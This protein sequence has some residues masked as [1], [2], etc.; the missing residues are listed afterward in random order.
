MSLLVFARRFGFQS[1]RA[2]PCG[3][4]SFVAFERWADNGA[5]ALLEL[6][7]M[8]NA[9]GSDS[10]KTARRREIFGKGGAI[11]ANLPADTLTKLKAVAKA[12]NQ[13]ITPEM[14]CQ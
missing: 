9:L 1:R 3:C 8:I 13:L 6:N 5:E 7:A 14:T 4:V 2:R 12:H 11:M 10:E